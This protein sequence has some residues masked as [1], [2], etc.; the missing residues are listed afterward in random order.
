MRKFFL[1]LFLLTFF[2]GCQQGNDIPL[3][4]FPKGAPP[5]PPESK[6]KNVSPDGSNTSQ[7]D[8]TT[9]PR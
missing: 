6:E 1:L 9:D 3:V 8:P 5:A 4:E 7:S 2:T